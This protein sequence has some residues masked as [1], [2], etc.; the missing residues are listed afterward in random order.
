MCLPALQ[1]SGDVKHHPLSQSVTNA[2]PLLSHLK[3]YSHGKEKPYRNRNKKLIFKFK[4]CW[5]DHRSWWE[6]SASIEVNESCVCS[7]SFK[8]HSESQSV[9][10][11]DIWV[12]QVSASS[13]IKTTQEK[14]DSRFWK[15]KN[16]DFKGWVKIL[17][18]G[19]RRIY[20]FLNNKHRCKYAHTHINGISIGF[21]KAHM[22]CNFSSIV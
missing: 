12:F 10:L 15:V 16:S 18:T 22:K 2:P 1:C 7:L 6:T 4:K 14:K 5:V 21:N 3:K 9:F 19:R 17:R 11:S 20:F 13:E 8:K